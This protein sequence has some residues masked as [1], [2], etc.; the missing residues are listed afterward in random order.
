MLF[1]FY[2]YTTLRK[3]LISRNFIY[4]F[5]PL[6]FSISFYPFYYFFVYKSI[7]SNFQILNKFYSLLLFFYLLYSF[8]IFLLL[9]FK[10]IFYDCYLSNLI[11]SIIYYYYTDLAFYYLSPP[12][13]L[14]FYNLNLFDLNYFLKSLWKF[15][16]N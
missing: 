1:I 5:L 9:F 4:H 14:L 7:S 12:Y 15:C 11:F 8:P 6:S 3:T 10:T 2:P 13:S 16:E